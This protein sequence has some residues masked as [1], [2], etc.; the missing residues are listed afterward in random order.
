MA[1]HFATLLTFITLMFVNRSNLHGQIKLTGVN[2]SGSFIPGSAYTSPGDSE[3]TRSKTT[4]TRTSLGLAFLLSTKTDSL[5]NLFRSWSATFNGSYTHFDHTGYLQAELPDRL[6]NMNF[7]I[8][9]VRSL[10]R[11]WSLLSLISVATYSDMA[12]VNGND[13]FVTAGAAFVKTYSPQFSLGFGAFINNSFKTPVLWPAI[14]IRWQTGNMFRLNV[15]LPTD[16]DPGAAVAYRIAYS[17]IMDKQSEI[18]L[19][20]KP[21]MALYDTEVQGE[22][23]RILTTWEIPVGIENRWR[24]N[25]LDLVAGA[26]AL[27]LRNYR[28][29][30]KKLSKMFEKYP[31]HRLESNFFIHLG[32][33]WS[34]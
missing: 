29:G 7:S 27:L 14:M 28:F 26:G 17:Y 8:Q 30:E 9:H 25:N 31:D 32:I 10:Q 20:F 33:G 13:F 34:L 18:S 15:D 21:R 2:V 16:K 3:G 12:K 6:A 5:K 19:V 1:Q 22:K 24:I 4:E 23:N 11:R